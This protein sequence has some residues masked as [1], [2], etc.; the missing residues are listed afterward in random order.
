L[1]VLMI[2]VKRVM[3]P[4]LLAAGVMAGAAS[5]AQPPEGEQP[6]EKKSPSFEKRGFEKKSFG[7]GDDRR[8]PFGEKWGDFDKR[9]DGRGRGDQSVDGWLRM[10]AERITDPHDTIRD[11]ARAGLVAAGKRAVPLLE[12]LAESG[13]DARATAARRVL[14]EIER[15]GRR[16]PS[17]GIGGFGGFG[18]GG[19]GAG[20]DFRGG[21]RRG[22]A[23]EAPMPRPTPDA[24]RPGGFTRGSSLSDTPERA[25]SFMAQ[26]GD[27]IDLSKTDDG[28]KRFVKAFFERNGMP[29]PADNA[30]ITK[31]K[32]LDDFRRAAEKRKEIPR[33]SR[34]RS[35]RPDR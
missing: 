8:P 28:R 14:E 17:G 13:D 9:G 6:R 30:V 15:Q 33:P 34:D 7:R 2:W 25:F 12:R 26:G 20:S 23:D 18:A 19:T 29:A 16:G 31:E 4:A 5:L 3:T 22:A 10:L 11:S 35:D 1:E 21:R 27:V 32:F 24:K